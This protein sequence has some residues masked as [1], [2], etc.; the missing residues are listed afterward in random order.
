MSNVG[1]DS[2]FQ[3]IFVECFPHAKD[4]ATSEAAI[5]NKAQLLLTWG[6]E[7]IREKLQVNWLYRIV[8]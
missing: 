2:F 3:Q 4:C 6:L 7:P 8:P 5:S 1:I